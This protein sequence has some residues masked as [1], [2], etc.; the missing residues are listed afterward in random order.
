MN[1]KGSGVSCNIKVKEQAYVSSVKKIIV[2]SC[3][4]Y[5]RILA[6][7]HIL[8]YILSCYL[9]LGEWQS[10]LHDPY[11]EPDS[12]CTILHYYK[13]ATEYDKNWYKVR[14]LLVTNLVCCFSIVKYCLLV[15]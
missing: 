1:L 7:V 5:S 14:I 12:I 10:A 3:F 2:L 11:Q 13:Y 4:S 15:I 9:K 8:F 6:A